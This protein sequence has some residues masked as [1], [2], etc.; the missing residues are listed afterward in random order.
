MAI[1]NGEPV[2][3]VVMRDEKYWHVDV[4]AVERV[5]Q[6]RHLGEVDLMARDLVRIMRD[7][8]QE[9]AAALVL[10]V[11]VVNPRQELV[12]RARELTERAES[13]RRESAVAWQNAA[14]GLHDDGLSMRDTAALLGVSHQRVHQLLKA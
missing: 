12:D 2:Q 3:V 5:T 4:P 7:L 14:R 10:D 11:H 1:M 9:Q 8:T 6:A 13:V